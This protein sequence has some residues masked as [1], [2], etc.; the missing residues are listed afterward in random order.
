MIN[1]VAIPRKMSRSVCAA[2]I[3]NDE[4]LLDLMLIYIACRIKR[5]FILTAGFSQHP[6]WVRQQFR[7]FKF[8]VSWVH[9]ISGMSTRIIEFFI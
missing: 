9:Y 6:I 5:S 2:Q 7:L 1:S 8:N 4:S 3:L